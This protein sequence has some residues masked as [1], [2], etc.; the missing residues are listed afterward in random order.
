M[1]ARQLRVNDAAL[2]ELKDIVDYISRRNPEN[3]LRFVGRLR[4]TFETL[5]SA[6]DIGR[7]RKDVAAGLRGIPVDRYIILYRH[8]DIHLTIERVLSGY[9]ELGYVEFQ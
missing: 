5:A 4:A 2:A 8:D 1:T 3:A 7:A 9:R 6:P